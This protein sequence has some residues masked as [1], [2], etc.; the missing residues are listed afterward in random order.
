MHAVHLC[1]CKPAS[2][3]QQPQ[4]AASALLYVQICIQHNL[5]ALHF[6]AVAASPA[7]ADSTSCKAATW[8]LAM[9]QCLETVSVLIQ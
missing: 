3:L 8:M 4:T 2:L 7:H 1:D 9:L 5:A 6:S